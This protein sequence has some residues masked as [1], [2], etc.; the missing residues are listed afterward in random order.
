M[1][2]QDGTEAR[3]AR[4]APASAANP[5]A[6]GAAH[7]EGAFVPVAEARLPLLDWGFLKSDV[8]YDV[9]GVWDGRFFRLDRHLERF[10][11]SMARLQMTCPYGREEVADILHAC[12]R[13]AALREAYVEMITTRGLAP[14]GSRDP[15]DCENRFYAFAIPYVW[16]VPPETQ[17]EGIDLTVASVQRIP[18]EAVDPRVKNFHWGDMVRG[19]FE[20]YEKGGQTAVLL[21]RDGN[22]TEGPGFNL[23]A[24]ID[25][26]LVTPESGVLEGITRRTVMELAEE[27]GRPVRCARL[28]AA[29][30]ARAE[31]IFLTSTAGGVMPVARLDGRPV[32]AGVPGPVSL[33]LQARYWAAHEDPRYATPVRY[34]D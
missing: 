33:D 30:L 21:D 26:A 32:G 12:V 13:R 11:A 24:L 22:V 9:V 19:L 18:P 20:A 7:V 8:T 14:A 28:P 29:E 4:A 1:S 6:D 34:E 5:F 25:G 17:K 10:F 31:E 27:A 3:A 2:E 16:I 23:F 15:R